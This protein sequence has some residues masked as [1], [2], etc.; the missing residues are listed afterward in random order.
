VSDRTT[1]MAGSDE[2]VQYYL[3]R[4]KREAIVDW[5]PLSIDR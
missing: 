3:D 2:I 5:K 4:K 1:A